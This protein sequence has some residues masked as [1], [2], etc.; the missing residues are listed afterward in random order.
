MFY[1]FI[2]TIIFFFILEQLFAETD[3][4]NQL[5]E[6][7]DDKFGQS[8]T[9]AELHAVYFRSNKDQSKQLTRFNARKQMKLR[10]IIFQPNSKE[11]SWKSKKN[12]G[13]TRNKKRLKQQHGKSMSKGKDKLKVKNSLTSSVMSYDAAHM[14]SNITRTQ[15]VYQLYS[16]PEITR[17]NKIQHF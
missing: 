12:V 4:E 1:T 9:E 6:Y 14:E 17:D 3:V 11:T 7:I 10:N 8:V 5:Q 16:A 13:T 2:F 15:V